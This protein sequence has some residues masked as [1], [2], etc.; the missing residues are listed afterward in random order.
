[1]AIKHEYE[2]NMLHD[3]RPCVSRLC[4]HE[5]NNPKGM[6]SF[7]TAQNLDI[8]MHVCVRLR[9]YY[10]GGNLS[11]KDMKKLRDVLDAALKSNH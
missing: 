10:I 4:V 8:G 3:G 9:S 2:L 11:R 7:K 5:Y 6:K 1:M